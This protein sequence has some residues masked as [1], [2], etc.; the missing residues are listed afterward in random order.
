MN[1]STCRLRGSASSSARKSASE[2]SGGASGE[3]SA[4]KPN[5]PEARH[6]PSPAMTRPLLWSAAGHVLALSACLVLGAVSGPEARLV[7]V[8]EVILVG[9]ERGPA[10]AESSGPVPAGLPPGVPG[11]P[12]TPRGAEAPFPMPPTPEAPAERETGTA[13]SSPVPA[14]PP[15]PVPAPG[16]SA[17][18]AAPG[19]AVET[20]PVFAGI[21]PAATSTDGQVALDPGRR[22]RPGFGTTDAAAGPAAWPL[23]GHADFPAGRGAEPGGTGGGS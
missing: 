19:P 13:E 15:P 21:R 8:V 18:P 4:V 1:G 20:A 12:P 2:E 16:I 3:D 5:G 22:E 6:G 9:G 23:P 17:G 10:G 14:E 11:L 7:P